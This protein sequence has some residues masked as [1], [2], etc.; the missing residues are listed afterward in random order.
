MELIKQKIASHSHGTH[1]ESI[2][3]DAETI[4]LVGNPNVGKSVVFGFLTGKYVTVSNY[5][6][7]TV[8]ISR[9]KAQFQGKTLQIIDTPG[10]NSLIPNSE[11]ERVTR[12]ILLTGHPRAI[13][14]VGD[15]KNLFRTLYL[16]IQLLELEVPVVLNLNMMDE[17]SSRGMEIDF[18]K[19]RKILNIPVNPSIAIRKTGLD[20]LLHLTEQA[21]RGKMTIYYGEPVEQAVSEIQDLLPQ[22][23]PVSR[24]AVALMLVA[25]DETLR[26]WLKD[27]IPLEDVVKIGDLVSELQRRLETPVDLILSRAR[28]ARVNEILRQVEK[29][30]LQP[31]SPVSQFLGRLTVHPI[32]G[33]PIL[34]AVLYAMYQVVGVFGAGTLVDFLENVVFGEWINP[35]ATVVVKKVI[36][37]PLLQDFLVG[38][39][40]MITMALSYG[41]AIILPIVT[42]FFLFFSVLEDSGYLPR[43]ASMMNR[44]FKVM[45]LNGKAILPMVLGLGC[46]T[47]ATLTTR[48]LETKKERIIVTLL[49]ALGVPCSA[50]L[51]VILAM[52]ASLSLTA[53]IVWMSVVVLV[54]FLVGYL[55]SK[56]VKGEPTDFII[57]L[58]PLRI[59]AFSNIM[60]KTIARIEWYL[61]EVI[62]LFILGTAILFVLDK[63]QVLG[64]IRNVASPVVQNWLGLPAKATDAF[65]IGFLRR[66]YGA[67]GLFNL[68]QDGLLTGN[69][70]LVSI[71]T[72]TLFVPC[73]ANFLMIIKERGLK[74]ALA[75]TAFIIPFAVLVGGLL[76]WALILLGVQF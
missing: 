34:L 26:E 40:G 30:Q 35:V 57:E 24:R 73:I 3:Q 5:P 53:S 15:A 8:E 63:I 32:W 44:V 69:Q 39:Y 75:M 71:I 22:S 58:P 13:I 27:H 10:T 72:I 38:E 70:I 16:T 55:S 42:T 74:T 33:V 17:A 37:I 4:T 52:T 47:M 54:L 23:L 41:F 66:D 64:A 49:L 25:G 59:P 60:Y 62:P 7:T 46:D 28:I 61:K 11:D 48:I 43:L 68:A 51:G 14:Q 36:P 9:G 20:N 19:L 67:A 56:I 21:P 50:Q 6:G 2:P 45:G 65:L 1:E 12:D 76:N 29:K 18:E 31:E